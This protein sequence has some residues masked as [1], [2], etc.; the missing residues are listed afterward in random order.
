MR[1]VVLDEANR[2]RAWEV[3]RRNR[4]GHW[5]PLEG[6]HLRPRTA[7][8]EDWL[9]EIGP[10]LAHLSTE[11]RRLLAD[12]RALSGGAASFREPPVPVAEQAGSPAPPAGPGDR[13]LLLR[14][15]A[16]LAE[17]Q[18]ER[19]RQS[20]ADHRLVGEGI[21]RWNLPRLAGHWLRSVPLH[22]QFKREVVAHLHGQRGSRVTLLQ[23][24]IVDR[25]DDI[26]PTLPPD[27]RMAP[28]ANSGPRM[29]I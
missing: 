7:L 29:R 8:A 15:L 1:P 26:L 17:L 24:K 27:L 11:Q 2:P 12:R 6:Q 28:R 3:L 10:L 23:T 20:L 18:V 5:E 14:D 9:A 16:R 22:W 4:N 21:A 25:R 19:A 13:D